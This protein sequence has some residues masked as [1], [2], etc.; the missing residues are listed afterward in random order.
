MKIKKTIGFVFTF[1]IALTCL[2]TNV[3]AASGAAHIHYYNETVNGLYANRQLTYTNAKSYLENMGYNVYGY[4]NYGIGML[5]G[6]LSNGE[7]FVVHNHGKPGHQLMSTSK[8]YLTA[9][10]YEQNKKL[11]VNRLSDGC[12]S[13]MKM[14]ILYGCETGALGVNTGNISQEIVNKGA[15]AAVSWSVT[16]YVDSVNEWNRLFFEK[17]QNDTI[18]ESYRHADYWLESIMGTTH[19]NIMRARNEAGN[20]YASIY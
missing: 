19:A 12:M 11:A 8:E 4:S 9:V 3:S 17:A 6:Q 14:V 18:V 20:I 5:Y 10:T 1:L 2:S 13:Q 16:T 15:T 7:I